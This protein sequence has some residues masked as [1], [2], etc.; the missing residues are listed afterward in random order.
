LAPDG[1]GF[2]DELPAIWR[3]PAIFTLCGF[4]LGVSGP[5][6]SRSS[7]LTTYF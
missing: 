6:P 7:A 4:I 2:K 3:K 5:M 1:A